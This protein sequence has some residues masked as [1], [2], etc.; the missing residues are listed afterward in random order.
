[1]KTNIF[2][3]AVLAFAAVA[4][5]N[6][7][8]RDVTTL[9]GLLSSIFDSMTNADNHVLEFKKD[10]A[11]LHQAGFAL[12]SSIQNSIDVAK[13]I[14]PL[15]QQDVID[16][17]SVSQEVTTIGAKLL[18]DLTV[19]APLFEDNGVCGYAYSFVLKLSDVSNEFFAITKSK[20]PAESQD[21]ATQEIA[22]TNAELTQAENALKP[23]VATTSAAWHTS[24][25]EPDKFQHGGHG[26]G[27]HDSQPVKPVTGSANS[28]ITSG[29]LLGLAVAVA[30]IL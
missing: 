4:Q 20:F 29:T 5:A 25:S 23:G 1:M 19:A 7:E 12:L 10:P 13:T 6:L 3:V 18:T 9:K 15:T 11:G 24:T 30:Y 22:T 16:I 17:A 27:T 28:L 26:N 8:R 2:G 21:M 14:E